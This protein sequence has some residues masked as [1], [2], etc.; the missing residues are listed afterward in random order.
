MNHNDLPDDELLQL[1]LGEL[2]ES[3][4]TALRKAVAAVRAENV[5]QL[6]A[7]F[8]DRLRRQMAEAIELEPAAVNRPTFLTRSPTIWRRIMRSPIPRVA[9]AAIFVLAVGGVA[10]WFHGG[11]T[12]PALADFLQPIL[13]AKTVKYKMTTETTI[14]RTGPSAGLAGVM[15][16]LSAETQKDLTNITTAE[17]MMLDANRS[18]TERERRGEPKTVE[19][20]DAGQGKGL[21]LQPAKKRATVQNTANM[22]K[23][24]TPHGGDPMAYY[25]SLLLDARDKP[26]VKREL[27]GEKEING[28]RVVGFRITL[29]AE[30]MRVWGDPK[31]GLPVRIETTVAMIPTIKITMS[32]FMFN[33]D[34]DQSL[35]SLE[36]PAGYK[37]KVVVL[38]RTIDDS[39]PKEKDL[40]EMFRYYSEASDGRFPDLLDMQWLTMTVTMERWIAGNMR[41]E[42]KPQ[43]QVKLLRGMT[44]TVQLPKEADA[45]YAGQGILLGAADRPIFWYRPKGSTKYR[46][47]YADLSVHEAGTP[48]NVPVVPIAQLEKDLI[49]IFRQHS[50]LSGGPFP[51]SLNLRPLLLLMMKHYCRNRPTT[52]E[53]S[54]KEEQE[55]TKA[56]IKLL[57]G[58]QFAALLPKEADAHYAG[59]GV[60]FGAVDKPI[61]WYRPKDAKRCRVIYADL[62]VHEADTPPSVPNAQQV[63]SESDR[64]T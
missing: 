52:T 23:G 45:H 53:R 10:L 19:I 43:A 58:L 55:I 2:D 51:D 6:S 27:L 64:K 14:E 35:F 40:I 29:P 38:D 31:T 39:R 56:R 61:F 33:V 46:V 28:R 12:T 34:M 54:A 32:D 36:P 62:S 5:G 20:W 44:F 16:W 9:A 4:Q 25:R 30:V 7:E 15:G 47:I 8:N 11:G 48:P 26:N 49:D 24:K 41:Q 60:S 18:R 50:K 21:W 1:L 17:V 22:P 37:V 13:N 57:R 42:T 3:R 59:K 63:P